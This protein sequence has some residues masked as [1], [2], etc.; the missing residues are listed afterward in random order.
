MKHKKELFL[1]L[2]VLLMLI[3]LIMPT[4]VWQAM[5]R[6]ETRTVISLTK[7]GALLPKSV[8]QNGDNPCVLQ[9]IS[10]KSF[11][12]DGFVAKRIEVKVIK[13]DEDSVM[14]TNIFHPSQ[15]LIVLDKHNLYDG[16]HVR[17]LK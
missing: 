12:Y 1:T 4:I 10:D 14:V 8:V 15:E 3:I 16:I 6:V 17:R 11:W 2:S 5:P 13:S 9:L 7:E